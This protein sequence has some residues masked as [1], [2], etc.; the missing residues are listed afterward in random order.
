MQG[1]VV[2]TKKLLAIGASLA[3]IH[4]KLWLKE[5]EPALKKE[6]PKLTVLNEDNKEVCPGCQKKVTYRIKGVEC[7]ACL[8]WYQLGCGS[9]LKSEYLNIAETVL[10]CMTCKKQQD[11]D[12]T[13]NGVNVFLKYVDDLVR[14]VKGDPGVVLNDGNKLRPN[15]QFA[16]EELDNNGNLTFLDLNVNVD[17][18]EKRSHV[19]G[20]K[21]PL[22][23]E[24]F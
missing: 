4:A 8:N 22:I 19:G 18:Q 14:T 12:R 2:R 15:L 5:Y 10:Y 23:P 6:I 11:A 7:E 13:E 1:F 20:T 21:N 17:T 9:L 16:L 24:P 3:V